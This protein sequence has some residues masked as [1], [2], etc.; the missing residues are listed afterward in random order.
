MPPYPINF[1]PA[2]FRLRGISQWVTNLIPKR[3]D[4]LPYSKIKALCGIYRQRILA[5]R[6]APLGSTDPPT[7]TSFLCQPTPSYVLSPQLAARLSKPELSSLASN[8]GVY[9]TVSTGNEEMGKVS[10]VVEEQDCTPEVIVDPEL[11]GGDHALYYGHGQM[12]IVSML[13]MHS[14]DVKKN[15]RF[16]SGSDLQRL[17]ASECLCPTGFADTADTP[18]DGHGTWAYCNTE[19]G[20]RKVAH[21]GADVDY[22]ENIATTSITLNLA[23]PTSGLDPD[24]TCP[25]NRLA[26]IGLKSRFTSIWA[27]DGK[28]ASNQDHVCGFGNGQDVL[29]NGLI[30]AVQRAIGN[31]GPEWWSPD[32]VD[33]SQALGASDPD[34]EPDIE[35]E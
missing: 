31:G 1:D 19:R 12:H 2:Q 34:L 15:V 6:A 13:D 28:T 9:A 4:S 30:W 27:C 18:T 26:A 20:Q 32:L 25:Y 29:V 11:N 24:R 3:V 10:F 7:V 35:E 33:H 21:V 17:L 5:S 22:T 8:L 16:S 23:V 14:S